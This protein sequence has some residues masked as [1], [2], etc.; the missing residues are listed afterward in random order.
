M[1]AIGQVIGYVIVAAALMSPF[2]LGWFAVR[3]YRLNKGLRA[4]LARLAPV[5]NVDAYMAQAAATY[6][7]WQ[8]ATA[9]LQAQHQALTADV[10]AL[11]AEAFQLAA[12]PPLPAHDFG[13]ASEYEQQLG[14]IRDRQERLVRSG[15]AAALVG[16]HA[17]AD[18]AAKR[19]LDRALALVLRAFNGECDALIERVRA[20]TLATYERRIGAA[21]NAINKLAASLHCAIAETYVQLKRQELHLV[22]AYQTQ[23]KTE[24]DEQRAIRAQQ[25]DDDRA[26]EEAARALAAAEADAAKLGAAVDRARREVELAAGAKQAQLLTQLHAMEAKLAEAEE[27][28]RRAKS[29]AEMTRSGHVYVI[30]NVGSFGEHVYKVGMTRRLEP[31]DRVDELGDASVPFAFDVHAMIYSN[32]APRLE[33]ALHD[34]LAAR[35]VNMVNQRKEFFRVTIEEIERV[36]RAHHGDFH[37]TRV[38]EAA[39]YRRSLELSSAPVPRA[40]PPPVPV[41]RR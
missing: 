22:H 27:R 20:D 26:V 30:S 33:K 4:E 15:T 6:Q 10:A 37:L 24:R 38:A 18:A 12:W 31:Q 21:A 9:S 34:M 8:A 39:E 35:R 41:A 16:W 3:V 1:E 7:Q 23:V 11:D 36:A 19:I 40:L 28:G 32:D 13:A 14:Q 29:M 2:L 5:A 25:R 17:P